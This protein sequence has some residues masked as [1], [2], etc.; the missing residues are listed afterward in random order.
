MIIGMR[1]V[2]CVDGRPKKTWM[3]G[4]GGDRKKLGSCAK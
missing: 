4:V 2:W 1:G 3:V